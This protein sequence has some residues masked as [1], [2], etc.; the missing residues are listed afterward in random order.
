MN[1]SNHHDTGRRQFL[2]HAGLGAASLG[3]LPLRSLAAGIENLPFG[4]GARELVAYPQKRPLLR[5]TTRPPHLETPFSVFGE[6][7]ITPNDAFFVRYHLANFPTTIDAQAYRLKVGG[8]VKQPLSLSLAELKALAEPAEVVAVNQCSGNSRA[9]AQ[10]RVFGAQLGNGSMGN[11]RWVGVPLRAVLEK[12]GVLAGARQVAFNGLDAPVLAATPDFVKAL[13]IDLALSPEPLIAWT[14]NGTDIPFLNGYPLKLIVPGYFGTY[15]VKHLSEIE[16]LDHDFD[17]FFMSTAY[18]VPDNA[19]M[20]VPAGT[21]PTATRP[22]TS[23]PVRS[24]MTSLADGAHVPA[25]RALLLKGIAFDGGSGI[26]KV[27]VSED[28]QPWR[29]AALGKDLGRFSF[30]EWRL[31]LTPSR[32]GPMTLSVRATNRQGDE[33]PATASWNPGGYA[34]NVIETTRIVAV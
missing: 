15:W 21:A 3:A 10:P 26:Q 24:F 16:V 14:M 32:K 9:F 11:A 23:L 12:A 31:P 5:I 19:C 33:Q 8:H 13:N 29:E 1:R 28:G 27:E 20:C 4:N 34:R 25:G 18:R 7:I 22:I 30:R 6:G 2:R 17:G